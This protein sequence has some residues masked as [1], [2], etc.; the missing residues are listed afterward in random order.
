M[1]APRLSDIARTARPMALLSAVATLLGA[2]FICL[3]P[4]AGHHTAAPAST[5]GSTSASGDAA[6]AYTCPYDKGACGLMPLVKPAVL[7]APPLDAPVEAGAQPPH[8]GAPP[9]G[10]SLPRS[11]AQP[12]APSLHV[13]Q[14][15]RT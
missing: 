5:S 2:L 9:A 1:G 3:S 7:T 8:L 15:L 13:L 14:V 11:G 6:A 10:A 12:R 4:P